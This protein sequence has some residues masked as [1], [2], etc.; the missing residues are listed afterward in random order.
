MIVLFS[1]AGE[2]ANRAST[3]SHACGSVSCLAMKSSEL[4]G[5]PGSVSFSYLIYMYAM[6][7]AC[8][9]GMYEVDKIAALI[10]KKI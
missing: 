10:E 9:R 7:Y 4:A 1:E 5:R 6:H 2:L 3:S 8:T